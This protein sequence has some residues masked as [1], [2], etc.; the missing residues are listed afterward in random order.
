LTLP[1]R[2]LH[3]GRG[4]VATVAST[5]VALAAGAA[6]GLSLTS[7]PTSA[8]TPVTACVQGSRVFVLGAG[9]RCTHGVTLTWNKPGTIGKPGATGA[10]GAT[11]ATG[12]AGAIGAT[13]TTGQ[14]G[15]QGPQ[16]AAGQAGVFGSN[17]NNAAG[18][19]CN[20]HAGKITLQFDPTTGLER[21]ICN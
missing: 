16:G 5:L 1:R 21:F 2:L 14:T 11:G 8:N 3:P 18:L 7:Q 15:A 19:S 20:A 10:S 12:Q 13:G 9:R 17:L 6:A 4:I